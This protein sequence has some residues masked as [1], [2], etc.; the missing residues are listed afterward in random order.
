[1]ANK[2]K[3]IPIKV[4][5]KVEI[6]AETVS[7]GGEQQVS[8]NDILEFEGVTDS[9]EAIASSIVTTFDKV[10]PK[11]AKVEF[12]LKIATKSGKLTNLLVSGS[13]EANLNITLEWGE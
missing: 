3:I 4:S 11:K 1:M 2:S 10:K 12:G 8:S 9:I 7:L 6:L 13:G 5:D